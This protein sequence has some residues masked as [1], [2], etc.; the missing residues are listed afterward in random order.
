MKNKDIMAKGEFKGFEA[1]D[2]A[3]FIWSINN[4]EEIKMKNSIKFIRVGLF[5][6]LL[7]F[8]SSYMIVEFV[9]NIKFR[10]VISMIVDIAIVIIAVI[11][12]RSPKCAI[13][14]IM[15]LDILS[16][17]IFVGLIGS[18]WRSLI[19]GNKIRNAFEGNNEFLSA[20]SKGIGD[21]G[22]E[23]IDS[24]VEDAVEYRKKTAN[25]N[26]LEEIYRIQTGEK[27]F[28]YFKES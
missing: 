14:R 17:V 23:D 8:L 5:S 22:Y 1:Y 10:L 19:A 20:Y 7:L 11:L 9:D 13:S 16:I 3:I 25:Q 12:L 6:I 2:H 26:E 24:A 27:I 15:I 21:K 18:F 28:V 4:T